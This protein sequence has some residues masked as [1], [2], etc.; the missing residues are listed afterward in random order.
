[1]TCD[2][3]LQHTSVLRDLRAVGMEHDEGHLRPTN[4]SKMTSTYFPFSSLLLFEGC[5]FY[6]DTRACVPQFTLHYIGSAFC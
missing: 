4:H 2:M 3:L 5:I 6:T 1:M